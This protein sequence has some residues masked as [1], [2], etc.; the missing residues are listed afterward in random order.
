M[1]NRFCCNLGQRRPAT[2]S[3][4]RLFGWATVCLL[5]CVP[6]AAGGDAPQW[7]HALVNAPLPAYDEKT[8]RWPRSWNGPCLL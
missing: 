2:N 1:K 7:M 3:G 5:V 6:C 4:A 8:T